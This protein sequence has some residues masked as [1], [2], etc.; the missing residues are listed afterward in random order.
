MGRVDAFL[1]IGCQTALLYQSVMFRN[2]NILFKSQ[3]A[4]DRRFEFIAA[5]KKCARSS[6]LAL[7]TSSKAKG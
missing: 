1:K 3:L 2:S 5:I 7:H 6:S 4:F